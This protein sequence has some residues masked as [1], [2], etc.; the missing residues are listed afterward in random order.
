MINVILVEPRI[1][2]NTGNIGRLCL[3]CDAKL[4][5]IRPFGFIL[6]SR[7]LKRAGMDYFNEIDLHIWDNLEAFWE[8]FPINLNHYFLSTKA[9][10]SHFEAKFSAESFLYFG[11][12]DAGLSEDILKKYKHQA[13]KIPMQ[14]NARSLN[15]S[16]AVSIV[17]YEAIR[18][19]LAL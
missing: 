19:N 13:Y 7:A 12:E 15:L 2:Q 3:C 6:N 16:N 10:K 17:V 18:Q 9:Q 5:L 11:R 14:N 1:P 4:H 8:A